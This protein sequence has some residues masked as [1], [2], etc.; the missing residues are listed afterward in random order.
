MK[1]EDI[2]KFWGYPSQS[3]EFDS[4]LNSLEMYERPVFT[5]NPTESIIKYDLGVSLIFRAKHGYIETWGE[6]KEIGEMIFCEIQL[7]GANN[8]SGFKEFSGPL[9][10]NFTF[11]S[12]L[13]DV[14]ATF[15]SSTVDHPSGPDN[16]V[17]VWYDFKGHTYG[18]CFLPKNTGISFLS[19]EKAALRAP[20]KFDW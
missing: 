7:Y 8:S 5:E 3:K 4:Y 18:V 12:T 10:F 19:I 15:G 13:D 9:P 2:A 11:S 6:P 14:I 1:L 16:R 20:V 17:H